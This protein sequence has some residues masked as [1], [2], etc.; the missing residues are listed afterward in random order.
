MSKD[1]KYDHSGQRSKTPSFELRFHKKHKD[2]V[3]NSYL[4]FI[5]NQANDIEQ[6]TRV[7]KLYKLGGG[8]GD[9]S[10]NSIQ[11]HHPVTFDK[12][13]MDD[14]QKKMI[15]DDLDRFVKRK[16]FYRRVGKAWKRGYLLYGPPG[17]GKSSLVAAMAN[18]LN[19]DIYDL[20]LTSLRGNSDFRRLLVSTKN[21]SILVVEDMDCSVDFQNPMKM[22]QKIA[23]VGE[24][25][26]IDFQVSINPLILVFFT[27]F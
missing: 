15:M 3:L 9:G 14:A 22:M 26:Q 25:K 12:L 16:D 5:I 8:N 13:A 21:Q 10:W 2:K 7:V 18:Y 17:T 19:F 6:E 11:L 27:N 4:P 20:E 23:V 24:G 1:G